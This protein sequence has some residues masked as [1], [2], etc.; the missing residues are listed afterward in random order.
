MIDLTE[1]IHECLYDFD[2]M[3][4]QLENDLFVVRTSSW[5]YHYS[6]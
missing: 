5:L 1:F 4:D 2:D 3:K 6:R